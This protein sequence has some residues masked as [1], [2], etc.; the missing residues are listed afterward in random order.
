M[1]FVVVGKQLFA[2]GISGC[3]AKTVIGP[4]DRTK[5][6]LQA[7]HPY[8]KH[9]GVFQC[10]WEITKREGFLSLWKGNTMMMIRI[11]PYAALQ[12]FAFEQFKSLYSP[13]VGSGHVNKLLSGSSAGVVAV[14]FT[15][16]LDMVRARLAFQITG[17]HHYHSI[18]HAF[19]KIYKKEGGIKGFYTGINPT[20]IGMIPYAGVSFYTFNALKDLLIKTSPQT[21][22]RQDINEPNVFVL[23]TWASL[24]CGGFAGA[25]SQTVSFPFDV[26]R[27]RMQLANLLADPHKYRT[28]LTALHSVYKDHGIVNGLYRGLSINY[29]RVVPQQAVAFTVY[30]FTKEVIGLNKVA[31]K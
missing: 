8:Y 21:F 30:E 2:G 19:I 22:A 24:C 16:P 18:K 13:V 3:V 14:L 9:Y 7:H 31:K 29:I 25:I 5:I 28:M 17:E 6:L 4:L 10:M 23:K 12:F 26:A 27:R 11:F 20:I 15:Y 1:D